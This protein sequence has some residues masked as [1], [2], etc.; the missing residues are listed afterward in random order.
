MPDSTTP[1]AAR[2]IARSLRLYHRDAARTGRMDALNARFAGPS[3]LVFDVGAHVGDRVA[4]FRRLGARV[5]AVDPQP[6]AMRALRLM[7]GRDAGVAL[8]PAAIGASAGTIRFYLNTANPTVSTV[9][10]GFIAAADGAAGWEGQTWD[11][12][13]DVA[14]VTLDDLIAAHGL[15]DFIKIDVEGHEPEVLAGLSHAVQALSFEFT[16]IQR[17]RALAALDRVAWLGARRFNVAPGETHAFVFPDWV[18]AAE[19]SAFLRDA[20]EAL[21]AGDVYALGPDAPAD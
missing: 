7:F 11:R 12:A 21:N 19:I 5:V 9:S 14:M 4:S 6:A 13:I 17:D 8:V 16:T 15:P 10:E 18:P 20:P 1:T 3:G 2:G